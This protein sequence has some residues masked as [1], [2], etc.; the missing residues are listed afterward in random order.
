MCLDFQ[1]SK[2]M[3]MGLYFSFHEVKRVV[4]EVGFVHL[5]YQMIHLDNQ[6]KGWRCWMSKGRAPIL[7]IK[8]CT[9]VL[10]YNIILVNF[11]EL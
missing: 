10:C 6:G 11:N 9:F 5:S 7:I 2:F 4:G 3:E 8:V 1:K